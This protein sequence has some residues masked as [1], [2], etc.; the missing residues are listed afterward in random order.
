[1]IKQNRWLYTALPGLS[2]QSIAKTDIPEWAIGFVYI[3]DNLITGK[4][5]VGKKSLNSSR[6]VRMSQK[7]RTTLATR[8]VFKIVKKESD[9]ETYNGSSIPLKKEI[10]EHP[11]QFRKTIIAWAF[12]KKNLHY[13][14]LK[15][16]FQLNVLEIDSYNEN[17]GARIFKNDVSYQEYLKYKK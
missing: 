11:E 17:I 6:R 10:A 4:I 15:Y 8:K 2:G 9:W 5:Y 13:L 1:M 12:S 14:E 3:I 16:Q 7:E